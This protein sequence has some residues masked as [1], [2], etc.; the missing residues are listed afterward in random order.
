[1]RQPGKAVRAPGTNRSD[2]P[3]FEGCLQVRDS[4]EGI[5]ANLLPQSTCSIWPS[6]R[7]RRDWP[8]S[9]LTSHKGHRGNSGGTD[10]SPFTPFAV[11]PT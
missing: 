11:H 2:G 9:T 7:T 5:A 4:G 3:A 8:T 10:L 6:A 1:M